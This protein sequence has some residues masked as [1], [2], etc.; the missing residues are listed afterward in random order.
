MIATQEMTCPKC[1]QYLGRSHETGDG[2]RAEQQPS[3]RE[4]IPRRA[5]FMGN[6]FVLNHFQYSFDI[7]INQVIVGLYV[8]CIERAMQE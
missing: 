8:R 5:L 4:K 7:G 2:K 3:G 6:P 1:M